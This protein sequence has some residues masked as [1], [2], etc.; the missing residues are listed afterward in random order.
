MEMAT[1]MKPHIQQQIKNET[2]KF[3]E[4]SFQD[5]TIDAPINDLLLSIQL[6]LAALFHNFNI[7][8]LV[9]DSLLPH[10][11]SPISNDKKQYF[12]RELL[13]ITKSF[14]ATAFC[15]LYDPNAHHY[16][17]LDTDLVHD[18]LIF[19]KHRTLDIPLI[20]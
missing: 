17:W 15:I 2:L 10:F 20:H 6:Q 4:I 18:Q 3:V 14:N 19:T 8:R 12:M 5:W 9:I 16:L 7:E 13:H 1:S 11:L